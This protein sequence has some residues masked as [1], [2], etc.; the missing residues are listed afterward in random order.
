MKLY[1]N[2]VAKIKIVSIGDVIL[3]SMILSPTFYMEHD[4][5]KC[6]VCKYEKERYK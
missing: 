1:G 4:K 5:S 2:S 6:K 3:H